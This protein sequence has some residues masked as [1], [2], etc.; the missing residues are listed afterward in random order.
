MKFDTE[1]RIELAFHDALTVHFEN[2]RRSK[3]PHFRLSYDSRIS[4]AF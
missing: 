2:F 4:P 3:A 1:A